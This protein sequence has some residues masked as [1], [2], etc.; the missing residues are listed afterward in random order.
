MSVT[1]TPSRALSDEDIDELLHRAADLLEAHH[2]VAATGAAGAQM[3]RA[4]AAQE[5]YRHFRDSPDALA[6]TLTSHLRQATGDGHVFVEYLG[7]ETSPGDDWI[8]R[9]RQEGPSRNW[10]VNAV[11]LLPGTIG[12]L[13]LTSFYTYELAASAIGAAME[14]IRHSDGLI[15][16]LTD[17]GGGDG[18][19]AD[20]VM[21]TFLAHDAPR[22]LVIESR[23]GREPPRTLTDLTWPRYD[24]RRPLVIMINRGTFS[25]PEAVAYALQQERRAIVVGSRSA[26]GANMIDDAMSLPSGF[27]LG[28]P[29]RRPIGRI[30]GANWEGVGVQP[31][32]ETPGDAALWRAWEVVRHTL[33]NAGADR[34]EG[35]G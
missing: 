35:S 13:K 28:I 33:A 20:A 4:A 31:D 16:D 11:R 19:T 6:G 25:A 1:G 14:L 5:R 3:L 18:T 15:L 23:E 9:W 26:G 34:K 32:V 24:T 30:T 27:K 10:G 22:P 2:V 8:V 7:D 29:N 12:F 21:D 17:N